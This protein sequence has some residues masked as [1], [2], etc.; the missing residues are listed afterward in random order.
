ML[1]NRLKYSESV[2]IGT[3]VPIFLKAVFDVLP[4]IREGLLDLRYLHNLPWKGNTTTSFGLPR[5]ATSSVFRKVMGRMY[6]SRLI[7]YWSRD[8]DY[9]VPNNPNAGG[10]AICIHKD[11]LLDDAMVTHM[12]TCQGR[13]HIVSIRSGCRNLTVVNFHFEPKLTLRSLR[14]RLRLIAPHWPLYPEAVGV[15]A[16]DFDICEPEEG[17][18]NVRN[19]SFTEGD[20]G[21]AALFHSFF[22]SC[23]RNRSARPYK[24]RLQPME[25][26]SHCPGLIEHS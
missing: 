10:S 26:Y 15:I 20:K 18:F 22:S 14:G 9:M 23:S 3:R 4:G 13:D 12:V 19:Q 8:S 25:E 2:W 16:G 11:L 7:R 1:F 21:K 24:E 17:R 5:T 6:C